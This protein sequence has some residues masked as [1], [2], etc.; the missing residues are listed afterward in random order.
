MT[1]DSIVS[2]KNNSKIPE[3]VDKTLHWLE[4]SRDSWKDKTK[5]VKAELKK[6]NLAITR[7]RQGRDQ[8][9]EKLSNERQHFQEQMNQKDR[10]IALL[11]SQVEDFKRREEELK[12]KL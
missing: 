6:K 9:Q 11:T 3:R 1:K 7:A 12:K 2:A 8:A 4:K 5:K 10:E